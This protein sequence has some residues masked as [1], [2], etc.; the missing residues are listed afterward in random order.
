[1]TTKDAQLRMD[2]FKRGG[3]VLRFPPG[4]RALPDSMTE[5]NEL[6]KAK[7]SGE[8]QAVREARLRRVGLR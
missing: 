5:W 4:E 6:R 3:L 2:Y 7:N 8:I 1:M